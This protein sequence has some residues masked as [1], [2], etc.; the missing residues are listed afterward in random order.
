MKL[1]RL[2]VVDPELSRMIADAS[3]ENC[4]RI[5]RSVA[6]LAV[7]E[8]Q[9]APQVRTA[10]I[11]LNDGPCGESPARAGLAA[12]VKELDEAAWRLQ[13]QD[14]NADAAYLAAFRRARAASALWFALDCDPMTAAKEATYEAQ[15]A[16][17]DLGR[18]RE[19]VTSLLQPKR[20]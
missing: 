3:A 18:V 15:A 5:A 6:K 19:L 13:E 2:A 12:L 17:Q 4:R 8:L 16:L 7:R 1:H 14:P 20:R 11:A 10:R 9:D